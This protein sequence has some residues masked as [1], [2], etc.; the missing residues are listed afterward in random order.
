MKTSIL[1]LAASAGV[2]LAQPAFLNERANSVCPSI[3]GNP[4]QPTPA[5]CFTVPWTPEHYPY[6]VCMAPSSSTNTADFEESCRKIKATARPRC[7]PKILIA[8]NENDNIGDDLLC[9]DP[10]FVA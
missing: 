5:C 10:Q 9:R 4:L 2:A 6:S 7:C 3:N 1:L 8:E